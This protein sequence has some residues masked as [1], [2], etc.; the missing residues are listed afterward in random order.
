MAAR[1]RAGHLEAGDRLGA[2][3]EQL[4]LERILLAG[5]V[6]AVGIEHAHGCVGERGHALD[7]KLHVEVAVRARREVGPAVGKVSVDAA[8]LGVAT[9]ESQWR[10]GLG[11][12]YLE[13]EVKVALARELKGGGKVVVSPLC[14]ESAE[15]L[16]VERLAVEVGL[17]KEFH[18]VKAARAEHAPDAGDLGAGQLGQLGCRNLDGGTLRGAAAQAHSVGTVEIA[19]CVTN[20]CLRRSTH[21]K[22]DKPDKQVA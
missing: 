4:A 7:Q 22:H 2:E 21:R 20:P 17:D 11:T 19:V 5:L 12:G 1:H 6:V 18:I 14:R 8:R 16:L 9:V 15:L 3:V 13:T 10:V